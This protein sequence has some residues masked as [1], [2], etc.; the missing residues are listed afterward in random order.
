MQTHCAFCIPLSPGR[1]VKDED[2]LH[3]HC[4]AFDTGNRPRSCLRWTNALLRAHASGTCASK[5][6]CQQILFLQPCHLSSEQWLS[7]AT[8]MASSQMFIM[9]NE[10][11]VRNGFMERLS[12]GDVKLLKLLCSRQYEH[13]ALLSACFGHHK[14]SAILDQV[15][16]S[17]NAA[18]AKALFT[19]QHNGEYFPNFVLS[20]TNGAQNGIWRYSWPHEF[21]KLMRNCVYKLLTSGRTDLLCGITEGLVERA[22]P[23]TGDDV[24]QELANRVIELHKKQLHV[25]IRTGCALAYLMSVSGRTGSKENTGLCA[26]K[27]FISTRAAQ[28][29]LRAWFHGAAL[30]MELLARLEMATY[31]AITTGCKRVL[32][33]KDVLRQLVS[34]EDCTHAAF[35]PTML[36]IVR[37]NHDST[38]VEY[39]ASKPD[40]LAHLLADQ[41]SLHAHD[42]RRRKLCA[43]MIT[44][45]RH[46]VHTTYYFT[47]HANLRCLL[48]WIPL[49]SYLDDRV[50]HELLNVAYDRLCVYSTHE[51]LQ[52]ISTEEY[53]SN[54]IANAGVM[55]LTPTVVSPDDALRRRAAVIHNIW[56]AYATMFYLRCAAMLQCGGGKKRNHLVDFSK[57]LTSPASNRLVCVLHTVKHMMK[58]NSLR[59]CDYCQRRAIVRAAVVSNS[60][61]S[62]LDPMALLGREV[63]AYLANAYMRSCTPQ[64][65]QLP[66]RCQ[67][68]IS[69]FLCYTRT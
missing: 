35:C 54:H 28:T 43:D 27:R 31:D 13:P 21:Q 46:N 11:F 53:V 52:N 1:Y 17:G 60:V 39:G 10:L 64:I 8:A 47:T 12:G 49:E 20:I 59:S 41:V 40:Q 68:T 58:I 51:D 62:V 3:E 14:P 63:K 22:L 16:Q 44:S 29:I 24:A 6:F 30:D 42:Q 57:G 25:V 38:H 36:S 32:V 50:F 48:L 56:S 2:V 55:N 19:V 18:S 61:L 45:V 15:L 67:N 69:K 4:I 26:L 5:H 23:I 66:Q 33:E 7:H 34:A 37:H 9:Y 65:F